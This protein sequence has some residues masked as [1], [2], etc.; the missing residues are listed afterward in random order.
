VDEF[1]ITYPELEARQRQAYR[2]NIPGLEALIKSP[3]VLLPVKDFSASGLAL[4]DAEARLGQG[5]KFEFDLLLN[6]KLLIPGLTAK[7][8]RVLEHGLVGCSFVD[9][10]LRKE[11]KLDKLVLE[12]QKRIIALK[13]AKSEQ[14]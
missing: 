2:T 11:A 10:D 7:T 4:V 1:T 9:L 14:E 12:V 13:K 5:D 6:K 3:R 8:M